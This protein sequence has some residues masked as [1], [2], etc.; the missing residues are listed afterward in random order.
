MND[1]DRKALKISILMLIL[2]VAPKS[3]AEPRSDRPTFRRHAAGGL[4]S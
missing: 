4:Q 2:W 3:T 1:V